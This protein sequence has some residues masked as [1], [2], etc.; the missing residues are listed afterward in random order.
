MLRQLRTSSLD[1][2]GDA[3]AGVAAL[4]DRST[5]MAEGVDDAVAAILADVRTR[6]DTAVAEYTRRFDKR[7]PVDGSYELSRPRWDAAAAQVAPALRDALGFAAGRIRAFHDRQREP[8]LDVT[9]DGVRLELRVTP[10]ARVGL[11]VP[12]GTALYPSS[13]LMTAIPAKV[14]GVPEVVMVTPGASSEALLAARLA[15][16][17]RVF[18]LGGAQA[19]AAL[20]YGTETVP[21]V[22][23]IVGPGNAWVASA[24]RQV[25]GE[26][27]IDSIAGPS[28]I[29]IIA[30]G[31]ADPAWVAADL[32]AQ[33]E[34]DTEARAVLVTPSPALAAAV[35]AELARQL[36][37]L[38][39]RAIAERALTGHGAAVI[40]ES[41]AAAV[42]LAN[43][44]APEHLELQCADARRVAAACTTAG[45]IFVGRYSSEAAGDYLAGGNHVLP[46]G[47]AARYASPLGVH[48][49]RKRTSLIEYDAAAAAAHADAI[50]ALAACEGLDGHGRS[51]LLRR[52][53]A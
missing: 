47:G 26:V 52:G 21:R 51:A 12:G 16:V 9:L 33:A 35:D 13:V 45:A 15:G 46:T 39:R 34:H 41:I 30:D 23:K 50:A 25:Y 32:I 20:A 11:Y 1:P 38:P 19:I 49:F 2:S 36:A 8:D 37:S 31:D 27:D 28:E 53:R 22:D 43:R 4:L 5:R 48:D 18:E 29:L 7:E 3:S 17:D 14:A 40:V 10:L 42:A 24:K 44:F 6:R